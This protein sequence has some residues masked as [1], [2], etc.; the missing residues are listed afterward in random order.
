MSMPDKRRDVATSVGGDASVPWGGVE[1]S[2]GRADPELLL[3]AMGAAVHAREP[4]AMRKIVAAALTCVVCSLPSGTAGGGLQTTADTAVEI[5]AV[6]DLLDRGS[7]ASAAARARPLLQRLQEH[8]DTT[9]LEFASALEVL[10]EALIRTEPVD[11]S[12]PIALA[13]R[14]VALKEEVAGLDDR[15]TADSLLL[16]G[17][18]LM[19]RSEFARARAV[20]DR[21]LTTYQRAPV[22]DDQMLGRTYNA[23]GMLA[24]LTGDL[25]TSRKLLEQGLRVLEAANGADDI[26]VAQSLV[27]LA[28]TLDRMGDSA[29]AMKLDERA[30]AI[31]R[32]RYTDHPVLAQILGNMAWGAD[33]AGNYRRSEELYGQSI[34]MYERTSGPDSSDLA[35]VVNNYG[36]LQW[37]FGDYEASRPLFERALAIWTKAQSPDAA[38]AL[39]NLAVT[40]R[41]LGDLTSARSYYERALAIREKRFGPNHQDVALVLFNLANLLVA[42][43][44]Y[45]NAQPLYERSLGIREARLGKTHPLTASTLDGLGRVLVERGHYAAA[46]PHVERAVSIWRAAKAPEVVIG[47]SSLAKIAYETGDFTAAL[48][49]YDEGRDIYE[50]VYHADHI[51]VGGLLNNSAAVLAA[52]GDYAQARDRYERAL[53]IYEKLRPD[54]P[55]ISEIASGLAGVHVALD[56]APQALAFALRSERVGRE[57]FRLTSRVLSEREAVTLSE[58]RAPAMDVLLSLAVDNRLSRDQLRQVADAVVRGRAL[59]LDEMAQRNELKTSAD[60]GVQALLVSLRNAKQRVANLMVRGPADRPAEY[61]R[62]FDQATADRDAA[63]RRLAEAHAGMRTQFARARAGFA[64]VAAAIPPSAALVAFVKYQHTGRQAAKRPGTGPRRKDER[65]AAVVMHSG[66]DDVSVLAIGPT[67]VV[68]GRVGEWR[69]AIAAAPFDSAGE[70]AY[71]RTGTSLARSVW[72]PVEPHLRGAATVL[73]VPDGTLNL[74]S[75][76]ALPTATGYVIESGP[77][78]HYLSAERDLVG[79]AAPAASARLLALGNPSYDA[80][81]VLARSQASNDDERTLA[82]AADSI[83]GTGPSCPEFQRL[84]FARLPA[85]S[86][87][88][89]DVASLWGA[90]TSGGVQRLTGASATE[91]AFKRE[92]PRHSILHLATHGFFLGACAPTTAATRGVGGVAGGRPQ[93]AVSPTPHPLALSGLALAGANGRATAPAGADDGI[94]TAEEVSSLDLR[95]VEWVV[96][97][98]CDTGV[99][100][101]RAGEGV[102][103]LR[104]AFTAAGARTMIMSL[105]SVEDQSTR[106]WMGH[107]YRARLE[108]HMT[109]VEAVTDA[110]RAMLRDR[111]ARRLSTH[112]FYWAAFVAAGN[113]R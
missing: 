106:A 3:P 39:N 4:A 55:S 95:G 78:V 69:H 70:I 17:S 105:W 65:Y 32:G 9:K 18:V 34:A 56:D 24:Q 11:S 75:F 40:A 84:R 41:R 8:R 110:G 83:R 63:E 107:L 43:G 29:Q 21:A 102:F 33:I 52:R 58:L 109:T 19:R 26:R 71:R 5:A 15:G 113:W 59:V 76:A 72:R 1:S 87:E 45:S 50:R 108:R 103:G 104:R 93:P 67:S 97:S 64:E 36:L 6:R 85:T 57:H 37:R 68:D 89:N 20:L 42:I 86:A 44:D 16:L 92:A 53:A 30:V 31:Y 46:R 25:P 112:P 14:A 13:E 91:A 23:L 54:H 66:S 73:I 88:V 74:V 82:T 49:Y 98:A 111:R 77:L 94:L 35:L 2:I 51:D 28:S 10:V 12:E 99:G 48:R 47:L 100:E 7:Y 61:R 101:V 90:R 96:L 60:A 27:S 81:A 22:P 62:L 38:R 80:S 79:D